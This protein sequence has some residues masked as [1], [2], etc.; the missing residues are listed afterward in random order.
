MFMLTKA[1]SRFAAIIAVCTLFGCASSER[2]VV[3]S[4]EQTTRLDSGKIVAVAL[5]NG[6]MIRFDHAG[7]QHKTIFNGQRHAIVGRTTTGE[8]VAIGFEQV[9]HVYIAQ[10]RA[11]YGEDASSVVFTM[12]LLAGLVAMR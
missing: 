11:G 12:M 7:A 2:I 8:N 4:K 6:D 3:R 1:P 10:H 5:I 9:D